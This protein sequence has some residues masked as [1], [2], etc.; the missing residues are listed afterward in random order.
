MVRGE[1][2][3]KKKICY[4]KKISSSSVPV[5]VASSPP[6]AHQDIVSFRSPDTSGNGKSG[7]TY[8]L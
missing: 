3:G 5:I 6:P 8:A 2:L 4:K 7:Q 1:K